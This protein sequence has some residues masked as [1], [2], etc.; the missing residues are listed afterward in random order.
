[1]ANVSSTALIASFI[2]SLLKMRLH[3]LLEG[4]GATGS[5]ASERKRNRGAPRAG[6]RGNVF[7]AVSFKL[8]EI[9]CC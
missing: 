8:V 9:R 1:M 4:N 2:L 7:Q 3:R 6:R 5:S